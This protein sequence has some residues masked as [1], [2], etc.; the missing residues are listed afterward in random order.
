MVF[1]GKR[2]LD[3]RRLRTCVL[4]QCKKYLDDILHAHI[5]LKKLT[6]LGFVSNLRNVILFDLGNVT[7]NGRCEAT[8]LARQPYG[9]ERAHGSQPRLDLRRSQVRCLR[10][11]F[12]FISI[13]I[14]YFYCFSLTVGEIPGRQS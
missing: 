9:I 10:V 6:L 11:S 1:D 8:E 2:R 5:P 3:C 14:Q 4:I 12:H 13:E 7:I